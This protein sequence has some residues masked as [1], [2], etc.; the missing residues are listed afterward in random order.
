MIWRILWNWIFELAPTKISH[1]NEQPAI[2][3]IIIISYTKEYANFSRKKKVL[4]ISWNWQGWMTPSLFKQFNGSWGISGNSTYTTQFAHTYKN[5]FSDILIVFSNLR[6]LIDSLH[7]KC[8]ENCVSSQEE[9]L[10]KFKN[11]KFIQLDSSISS[12]V[13]Y[14]LFP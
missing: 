8:I 4:W 2:R 13:V 5:R 12:K 9:N 7:S 10:S 3:T 14:F 1:K 11:V 6:K